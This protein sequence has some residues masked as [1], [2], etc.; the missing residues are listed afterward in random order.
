MPPPL[1]Q[2]VLLIRLVLRRYALSFVTS[3]IRLGYVISQT[4]SIY[5]FRA[6]TI[7]TCLL[8]N[9]DKLLNNI[10]YSLCA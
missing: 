8:W 1:P 9:T 5:V 7:L 6:P 2:R 10:G 4:D 3:H